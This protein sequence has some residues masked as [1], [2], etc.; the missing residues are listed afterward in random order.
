MQIE[1]PTVI[2]G[3]IPILGGLYATALGYGFL[4]LGPLRGGLEQTL[5]PRFK[6]LGP[7]VIASGVFTAW[8][9]HLHVVHPPAAEIARQIAARLTFP[10]RVDPITTLDSVQGSENTI[11]YKVSIATPL[12]DLGGRSVMQAKLE[13]LACTNHDL[14]KLS[15]AY[16]VQ[17]EYTFPATPSPIVIPVPPVTSCSG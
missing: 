10:H 3:G 13:R 16:S 1:W 9:T 6:W 5:L 4:R 14:Q 8:E 2:E 17:I 15:T 12:E 7:F 11:V